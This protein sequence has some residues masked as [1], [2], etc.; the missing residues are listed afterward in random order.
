MPAREDRASYLQAAVS[1]WF[2]LVD[3]PLHRPIERWSEWQP[4]PNLLT[5]QERRY[6]EGTRL[7][8]RRRGGRRGRASSDSA[9]ALGVS[10]GAA[11]GSEVRAGR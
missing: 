8:V 7:V 3:K 1:R 5:G 4:D 9:G 2:P 6:S 11:G 10:E